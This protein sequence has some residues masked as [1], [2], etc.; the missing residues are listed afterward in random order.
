[1]LGKQFLG[2]SIQCKLASATNLHH[3]YYM[4]PEP[5]DCSNYY[6]L[7]DGA[8]G[9]LSWTQLFAMMSGSQS[10]SLQ[11]LM[12]YRRSGTINRF[13]NINVHVYYS[14]VRGRLSQLLDSQFGLT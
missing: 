8:C 7:C 3:M 14:T 5:R 10:W 6:A 2:G 11:V 4:H 1:M 9:V 13:A 12:H